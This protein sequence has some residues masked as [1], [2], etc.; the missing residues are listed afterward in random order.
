[1]MMD[2]PP[3]NI[4]NFGFQIDASPLHQSAARRRFAPK[5]TTAAKQEK[6]L[7]ALGVTTEGDE[8]KEMAEQGEGA[9]G[10]EPSE[11]HQSDFNEFWN[12]LKTLYFG[13][14]GAAA[15][16]KQYQATAYYS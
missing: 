11:E 13:T 6:A 16:K 1:M 8:D 4:G 12:Q 14:A 7:E 15:E 10:E 2:L 9:V 3:K 5:L